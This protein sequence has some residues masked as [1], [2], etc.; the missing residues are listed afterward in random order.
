MISYSLYDTK[1]PD[2]GAP[3]SGPASAKATDGQSKKAVLLVL[4]LAVVVL[5][6]VIGMI[7]WWY[8]SSSKITVVAPETPSSPSSE[9]AANGVLPSLQLNALAD[10]PNVNPADVG[11]PI[12]KIKTNPFQ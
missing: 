3:K 8:W 11:N 9:S 1:A 12:K 10:T 6:A 4:I 2:D 7:G 5:V